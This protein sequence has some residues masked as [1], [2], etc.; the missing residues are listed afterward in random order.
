M[1][2]AGKDPSRHW[3]RQ[4]WHEM[5]KDMLPRVKVFGAAGSGRT[6]EGG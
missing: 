1:P 2:R 5:V 4:D 6:K 3:T